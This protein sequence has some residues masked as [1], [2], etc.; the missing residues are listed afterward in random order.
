VDFSALVLAVAATSQALLEAS[1][2][3]SR[4]DMQALVTAKASAAQ[5][6]ER[7]LNKRATKEQS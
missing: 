6:G 1:S 4:D 5:E 7:K 2:L 3:A